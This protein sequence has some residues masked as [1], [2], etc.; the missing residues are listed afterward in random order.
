MT[1]L[2][3]FIRKIDHFYRSVRYVMEIDASLIKHVLNLCELPGPSPY[4][5]APPA[6]VMLL[7]TR[8]AVTSIQTIQ[9]TDNKGYFWRNQIALPGGHI[10]PGDKSAKD[11]AFRELHEELGISPEQVEYV[12]R[13]GTFQ[14]RLSRK[15]VD[16][17]IGYFDDDTPLTLDPFEISNTFKVPLGDLF[18]IHILKDF[19]NRKPTVEELKY[20][21]KNLTIWGLTARIIHFF[22]EILYPYIDFEEMRI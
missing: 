21:Y 14:T 6:S 18:K 12:G 9:K 17:F 8:N 20:P 3:V 11:A 10:D 5:V 1:F 7:L 4:F 16:A 22:L 13:L 2:A 15:N 19:H